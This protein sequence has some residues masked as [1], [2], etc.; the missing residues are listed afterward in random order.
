[1]NSAHDIEAFT[2]TSNNNNA[3]SYINW[4]VHGRRLSSEAKMSKEN[5]PSYMKD[6]FEDLTARTK[7]MEETPPNEVKYWFEYTGPLQVS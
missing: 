4:D 1:M 6:L 2:A 7:L 5:P 3:Y